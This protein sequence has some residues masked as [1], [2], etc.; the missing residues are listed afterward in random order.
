MLTRIYL[1]LL[2]IVPITFRDTPDIFVSVIVACR[3]EEHNIVHLLHEISMQNFDPG[4][5]EVIVIDDNSTDKTIEVTS[6]FEG[7]K[8][9]ILLK[10][11]GRGKKRAIRTGVDASHGELIVTTDADC[12]PGREWLTSIASF[13]LLRRPDL[14]ICPVELTEKPGF[15]NNFQQLEFLGLQG[16]TAGTASLD[17]PV[18]CNGA[19]LAF[20]KEVYLSNSENLHEELISGDDI[21]LLHSIKRDKNRKI[22][23]L[24]ARDAII[25]TALSDNVRSFLKQRARWI[26]KS[27][28]ISDATTIMTAIV[29]FVTILLFALLPF[30]GIIDTRFLPVFAV[31]FILK[32]IPDYLVIKTTA[33]RYGLAV[34]MRWFLPSQLI[35]PFY[36]L[37]VLLVFSVGRGVRVSQPPP[38]LRLTKRSRTMTLGK[39]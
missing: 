10:N 20:T 12:L 5:F 21:F 29:T 31:A 34:A 1:S 39:W 8:N 16:V 9:L 3:N 19:N 13:Y 17:N 15:F 37:L 38:R 7:I 2:K 23:W 33:T 22:M 26:S 14:I 6:G 32:S 4:R 35:Y 36:V 24:E 30:A 27:G 28:S 25:R 18:M 11:K